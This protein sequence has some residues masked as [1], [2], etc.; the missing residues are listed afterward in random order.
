MNTTAAVGAGDSQRSANKVKKYTATFS[1]GEFTRKSEHIYKTAAVAV[2]DGK[3]FRAPTFSAK[4]ARAR[5]PG[6]SW[7]RSAKS[8]CYNEAQRAQM[9]K[10]AAIADAGYIQELVNVEAR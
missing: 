2:K 10:D 5:F 6:D 9:R 4:T 8:F 3:A 7:R 1:I